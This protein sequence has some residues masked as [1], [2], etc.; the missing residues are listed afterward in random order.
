MLLQRS[1]MVA[2]AVS[3]S[4]FARADGVVES[5]REIPVTDEVDVLVVGGTAAGVAAATAAAEKGATVYLAG[6]F[7][8]LGEDMAGTLEL[9][10]ASG[11]GATELERKLRRFEQAYAPY[12]YD[13]GPDFRFMGG[14]EYFGMPNDKFANHAE[15]IGPWDSVFYTNRVSVFCSFAKEERI[16]D[17]EAG[18]VENDD[19]NAEAILSVDHRG[20]LKPGQRGPLTGAIT[21]T[22]LDGPRAGEAIPLA[23]TGGTKPCRGIIIRDVECSSQHTSD[24]SAKV[25]ASFTRARLDVGPAAGAACHL[26]SRIRFR[27]ASSV[28]SEETPTP[29]TVKRVFDRALVEAGVRFITGSP[30]SDLI[31]DAEGRLAGAVVANRSGRQAILAKS[32]VDATRYSTL[33]H[34]GRPLF[35]GP[36]GN[37]RFTRV[38]QAVEPPQG[39]SVTAFDLDR[40]PT[41]HPTELPKLFRCALELPMADWSYASFA[42]AEW[43]A[44]ELTWEPSTMDDAD[45]LRLVAFPE[46]K[47]RPYL[48][49]IPDAAPLGARIRAGAAAGRAA[50]DE[51]KTRETPKGVR[52]ESATATAAS[53]VAVR[54]F[55][56]GL[57]PY[58]RKGERRTVPSPSRELPIW[59]DYDVIV[60][61]GGTS[62]TPAAIG[63]ARAGAKT[64]L[65]EYIHALGGVGTDGRVTGYYCG[66][67]SGFVEE[68]QFAVTHSDAAKAHGWDHTSYPRSETW[69]RMCA[70][71]GVEVWFGTM[72]EG[73]IVT[74]KTV[75]GVVMVTPFGRG[76]VRAKSVID[77]TGNSDVAA[78]AGAKTVFLGANEL[79]VQS[80][81]KSPHRYGRGGANSDF[82]LVNDTDAYDLWLFGLRAHAG[83][84]TSWDIQQMVNSRERRRIVS[85]Y[86]VQGWDAIANRTFRDTLVLAWSKQDG[87]GYFSDEFGCVS[88]EDGIQRR[89]VAVPLRSLLP[90]GLGHIAVIGLGKGVGR[91]VVPYV[92]M[93]ADLM[94]EGYATG[95]CAAEAAKTSGGDFRKADIRKV[96]RALVDTGSLP[97]YVLRWEDETP[98]IS[99]AEL[100]AAVEGLK[101]GYRG[102]EKVWVAR[103]RARPLLQA[104][105]RKATTDTARQV[106]AVMLGLTGDGTGAETLAALLDGR[107]KLWMRGKFSYGRS[108]DIIGVALAAGRVK[109]KRTDEAIREKVKA[110]HADASMTAFRVAT[111]AAEAS[112]SKILAPAL[113]AALLK[114]GVGGWARTRATDLPPQGGYGVGAEIDRCT[115][116]LALARALM[117]CGDADGLGRKTLEAYMHDPRGVYAEHASAVLKEYEGK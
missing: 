77:A 56:G 6:G 88:P 3:L 101:D 14:W 37:V 19:P 43:Q 26:L 92:R 30:A 49:S 17:V 117:A 66:N 32:V 112:G 111:L 78:A 18:V 67:K 61:G 35:E 115:K 4:S 64:L 5:A 38:I 81:G 21:L 48:R 106:Y 27:R 90:Q 13:H 69:R 80:A 100:A 86:A 72:A 65:V 108:L 52:V 70:A 40:E 36:A 96:Q 31:V 98:E 113:A 83:A 47:G 20:V 110:L 10:C 76:V 53:S 62:G 12:G 54:E 105:Y 73:A 51:A 42:R 116:E 28:S 89:S 95:L 71:A 75:G 94:N 63:A 34:L 85:D 22:P 33:S 104:A 2:A 45:Q 8:Y 60:V 79:A 68:F 44:R 87:H 11:D 99:D 102:S 57:R 114:P 24:F 1:L 59:G 58:E 82:G 93:Q 9:E 74:G 23:R 107:Q 29:L 84:P 109:D 39:L 41:H 16:A 103:D 25:D 7:T 46:L 15:P 91:D 50:A 97:S 55:L